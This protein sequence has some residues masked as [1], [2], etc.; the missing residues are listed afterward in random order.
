MSLNTF[1]EISVFIVGQEF[2]RAVFWLDISKTIVFPPWLQ[3]VTSLILCY[4]TEH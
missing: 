4:G 1:R 2:M 3:N